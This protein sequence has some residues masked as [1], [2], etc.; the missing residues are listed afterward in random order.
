MT[1]FKA[2][3]LG[4]LM[5]SG[6]LIAATPA[7]AQQ[8]TTG[9]QPGRTQ[10]RPAAQPAET[11]QPAAQRRYNLSRAEQAAINPLLAANI[12]ANNA[13]AAANW[14]G[15]Q[16]LLP[17][18]QAAARGVDARYLI[19][20]VQLSIAIG[21]NSLEGQEA[22]L[23]ALIANTST[24]AAEAVNYR[25]AQGGI[26]NR[27]AEQAFQANDFATAERLYRQLLQ[28]SPG[29]TRL[30]A[31]LRIVQERSGNTAGVLEGVN[32]AIRTAEAAGGRATEDL[33]QRAWQ[34]PHAAGQRSAAIAGLQR[35]L[36][37]YPTPANWRRAVDV[38]RERENNDVQYLIDIYRLGRIANVVQRGEFG[39]LAATLIQASY[40]GEA[41]GLLD[42]GIAAGTITA[43]QAD[44]SPVLTQI[45][46]RLAQDQAGL[47]AEIREARGSGS[48]RQARNV[49]D[50]LYGYGRYAEA[51][52][53]YRV[54]LTKGGEDANLLNVRIGASL[55]MA[56]QRAEAETALRAV[57]G[58]RS[59]IAAFWLTWLSSRQ[60]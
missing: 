48:A 50:A 51:A 43:G 38:L 1:K 40:Y 35:L 25:N 15:V 14:A 31:N 42:A 60:G 29:D 19:A 17:A 2:T 27:R 3:T 18:A 30:Q 55:A 26:L 53:L 21:T 33:Y 11:A 9:T 28:A 5:S 8:T 34:V 13:G 12:A 6:A 59:E 37:A 45:R 24:P 22:A 4:V 10:P 47:A 7:I 16:A 56:G 46:D 36:T 57:T 39:P 49:A 52:E 23:T 44:V 32:E 20:R 54:A 41:K 58:T